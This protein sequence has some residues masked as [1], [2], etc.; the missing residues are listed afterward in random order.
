MFIT[1]NPAHAYLVGDRFI[2]LNHGQCVGDYRKSEVSRTDLILKM[3]AGAELDELQHEL[4]PSADISSHHNQT[5][6]TP[7]GGAA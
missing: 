7:A 2:L 3:S 6:T 5:T 4:D 1:H